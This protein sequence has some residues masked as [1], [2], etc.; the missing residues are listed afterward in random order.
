MPVEKSATNWANLLHTWALLGADLRASQSQPSADWS[1]AKRMIVAV[2]P[3]MKAE[4]E[5]LKGLLDKSREKLKPLGEPFD[6]DLGLHRWLNAEREEA[7]S[8][9][10][11][12][13]VGQAS[14]PA[15]IFG[16]FGLKVPEN[17]LP[18]A[19]LETK[20]EVPVAKGHADQGGRL[21]LVIYHHGQAAM[22]VE[23][24]KGDADTADTGKQ[25]G[26]RECYP[27]AT[28]VLLAVSAEQEDYE[29]FQPCTWAN[30]C[31][32]MRL[33][34]MEL[35]K[36]NRMMAAAMVLAFVAAV[37]QNL[38]GFSVTTENSGAFLNPYVLEYIESFL[39]RLE[40]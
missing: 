35:F 10:L 32:E 28:L 20:R 36:E 33:L 1:A 17:V 29:G 15:R 7:Y 13:V 38:L 4:A 25:L 22:V 3:L 16:L 37:E 39:K 2:R 30:V 9:W 24:K 6:L 31:I 18:D 5:H 23:V 21:D 34:A 8:D 19:K 14:T 11:Q 26:Y 27:H 40:S 12:W